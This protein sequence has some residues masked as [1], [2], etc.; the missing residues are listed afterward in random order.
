MAPAIAHGLVGLG[1][2]AGIGLPLAAPGGVCGP[3]RIVQA[4]P[5]HQR[6]RAVPSGSG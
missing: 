5:S 1:S 4:V 6:A 2:G 3:T